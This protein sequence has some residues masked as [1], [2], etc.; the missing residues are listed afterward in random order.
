MKCMLTAIVCLVTIMVVV[1]WIMTRGSS[2]LQIAGSQ[3]NMVLSEVPA[4]PDPFISSPPNQIDPVE[5]NEEPLYPV[6]PLK[7]RGDA[8]LFE[9]D[10]LQGMPFD[11]AVV[12]P[13]E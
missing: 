10:A 9:I 8:M 11:Q 2:E 1:V 4:A 3:S 12:M 13:F 7:E 6:E 5:M